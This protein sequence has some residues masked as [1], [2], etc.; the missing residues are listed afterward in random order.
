[1][2]FASVRGYSRC[3][4]PRHGRA[5]WLNHA[6][7]P[8]LN[9]LTLVVMLGIVG[10]EKHEPATVIA[11]APN[12]SEERATER[13][14]S[15]PI[16]SD[17]NPVNVPPAASTLA[18]SKD[19]PAA[20]PAT[21]L[22]ANPVPATARVDVVGWRVASDMELP[23][24]RPKAHETLFVVV[25]ARIPA[26][27]VWERSGEDFYSGPARVAKLLS[28][29]GKTYN[30]DAW[31]LAADGQFTEKPKSAYIPDGLTGVETV[32]FA[33]FV[34]VDSVGMPGVS[35]QYG[36]SAIVELTQANKSK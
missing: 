6:F 3:V 31:A 10:C 8:Q 18:R 26:A 30:A 33:F 21:D 32:R 22:Q 4:G 20:K 36:D 5:A 35:L 24:K 7:K 11:T 16:A 14:S 17:T 34:A 25:E 9:G 19:E 29:K 27:A 28:P 2:S 12:R 1:M 13:F 15:R 23:G